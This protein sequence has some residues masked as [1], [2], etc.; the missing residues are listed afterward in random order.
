MKISVRMFA[1]LKEF[2]EA[3]NELELSSDGKAKLNGKEYNFLNP[4]FSASISEGIAGGSLSIA[5]IRKILA[6]LKPES[7]ALLAD[8]RSALN[9]EFSSDDDSVKDSDELV[10]LPPSSGG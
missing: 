9:N 5:S 6:A 8:C 7:S 10:F 2:F 1:G 3:E 4:E